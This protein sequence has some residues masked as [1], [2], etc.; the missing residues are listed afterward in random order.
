MVP[1]GAKKGLVFN[2]K[3]AIQC[4]LSGT[5]YFNVVLP[6]DHTF[7]YTICRKNVIN[8]GW[9]PIFFS[10]DQLLNPTGGLETL[11]SFRFYNAI[12]ASTFMGQG[13]PAITAPIE[14]EKWHTIIISRGSEKVDVYYDGVLMGSE[15]RDL[16]KRNSTH[17]GTR[18]HGVM[19]MNPSRGG[20]FVG[21]NILQMGVIG[22]YIDQSYVSDIH[23]NQIAYYGPQ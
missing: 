18:N 23:N 19:P 3:Y 17:Y 11:D 8:T 14:T 9:D 4:D 2:G 1:S 5:A 20:R 21:V 22:S 10:Y 16:T 13:V 6:K 7:I 15:N 12:G